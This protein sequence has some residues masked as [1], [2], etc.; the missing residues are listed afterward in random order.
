LPPKSTII[1]DL[2]KAIRQSGETE[3]GV[4]KASGV[5]Q[6]V[7][8]RFVTGKRGISLDTAAKLTKHLGLRL[9]A[10]TPVQNR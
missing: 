10:E 5:P 6:S 1:D 7:V 8:N 4:A 2:R 9:I 3:Y